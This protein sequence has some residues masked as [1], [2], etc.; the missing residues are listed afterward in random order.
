M[1][2]F[3]NILF[4]HIYQIGLWFTHRELKIEAVKLNLHERDSLRELE[5]FF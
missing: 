1:L 5:F 2:L 4:R 3:Q